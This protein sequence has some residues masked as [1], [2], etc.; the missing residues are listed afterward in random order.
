[1][2]LQKFRCSRRW[3]SQ[4]AAHHHLPPRNPTHRPDLPRADRYRI[5]P[6]RLRADQLRT[7]HLRRRWRRAPRK[8]TSTTTTASSKLSICDRKNRVNPHYVHLADACA[9]RKL[10]SPEDRKWSQF[11][12]TANPTL[13][14]VES[15]H[16]ME[17]LHLFS[18]LSVRLKGN[19]F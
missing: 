7:H 18:I 3:G 6:L 8:T 12:S 19:L 14:A 2:R 11:L 9:T 4:M 16:L 10:H 13:V 15:P 17:V 5:H 1:Q